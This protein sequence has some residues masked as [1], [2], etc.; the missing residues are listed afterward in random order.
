MTDRYA[1]LVKIPRQPAVRLLAVANCKLQTKLDSPAAAPVEYVLHELI[2]KAAWVD[3]LML[4]ACALPPRERV[5][6]ACLAAR[7]VIPDP[8]HP[9][10]PL[11]AAEAWVYDP[12][13]ARREAAIAAVD[14]AEVEDETVHCATAVAFFD[15]TLGP[16]EM[17]EHPAPPG[18]SELSCFAMNVIAWCRDAEKMDEMA[19][20]LIDRALDI[21]RGGSGTIAAPDLT[22]PEP[23]EEL[24]GPE[25]DPDADAP[26]EEEEEEEEEEDDDEDGDE[27][28]E[29]AEPEKEDAR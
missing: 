9:P 1:N 7:D 28:D 6:W 16:G 5:W 18:A 19:N 22:P 14:H 26:D 11:T 20:V 24:P 23:E 8:A 2:V 29:D 15:G 17:A 3:A 10:P 4:L 27:D 25:E 12:K 21:A 13:D